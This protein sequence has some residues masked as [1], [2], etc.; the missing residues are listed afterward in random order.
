MTTEVPTSP[1]DRAVR[2]DAKILIGLLHRYREDRKGRAKAARRDDAEILRP[3]FLGKGDLDNIPPLWSVDDVTGHHERNP[4][5][6]V[7]RCGAREIGWR[8]FVRGGCAEMHRVCDAVEAMDE[9][10]F[11]PAILDKWWDG[12]GSD[13]EVW[14]S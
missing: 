7:L 14:S 12:I 10:G 11:A 13:R 6:F 8:A 5:R 3:K 9:T 4:V 2:Y 1:A